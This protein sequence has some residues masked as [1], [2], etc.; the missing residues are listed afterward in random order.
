MWR[1][2]EL[3]TDMI[4]LHDPFLNM[5]KLAAITPDCSSSTPTPSTSPTITLTKLDSIN[6]IYHNGD[7]IKTWLSWG[8]LQTDG[9]IAAADVC[10]DWNWTTESR[11]VSSPHRS[12]LFKRHRHQRGVN[13]TSQV[14]FSED[15]PANSSP[16]VPQPPSPPSELCAFSDFFLFDVSLWWKLCS[17]F[18]FLMKVIS[19]TIHR[20]VRISSS[21]S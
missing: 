1:Q 13:K 8:P 5:F 7:L 16:F 9:V 6:N 2:C 20:V 18:G 14:F 17:V 19:F 12:R 11:R 10:G 15:S 4:L 21:A 3:D